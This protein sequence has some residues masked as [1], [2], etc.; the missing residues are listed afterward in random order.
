VCHATTLKGCR[1]YKNPLF[2]AVVAEEWRIM[3]RKLKMQH[4]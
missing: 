2:I 1:R 3:W 4:K